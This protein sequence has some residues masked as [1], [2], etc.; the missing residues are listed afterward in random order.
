MEAKI[1]KFFQITIILF[2]VFLTTF[3]IWQSTGCSGFI[4]HKFKFSDV[5]TTVE[6]QRIYD[7]NPQSLEAKIFSNKFVVV[8]RIFLM[9]YLNYFEP[10]YLLSLIGPLGLSMLLVS[11]WVVIQK[12]IK[13]G[14]LHFFAV[15]AG[16]LF[17]VYLTSRFNNLIILLCLE[18]FSIWSVRFFSKNKKR[19]SVFV[20]L[21]IVSLW[22]FFINWQMPGVCNEMF[23][24]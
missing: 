6:S 23:F 15:I 22:F 20:I 12:R 8:P 10:R 4:S 19:F 11:I 7:P 9:S 18:S 16:I 21:F 3:R 14:F 5:I 13:A 1:K 24:K 2:V 17:S